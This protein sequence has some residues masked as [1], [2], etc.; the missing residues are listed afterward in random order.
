MYKVARLVVKLSR[1]EIHHFNAFVSLCAAYLCDAKPKFT[2]WN[3][4]LYRELYF[5]VSF[6]ARN[7]ML[8]LQ[9]K[10]SLE[11]MFQ[12]SPYHE[13]VLWEV[14]FLV[15][16]I[17]GFRSKPETSK[18]NSQHR[19]QFLKCVRACYA[20]CYQNVILHCVKIVASHSAKYYLYF[21]TIIYTGIHKSLSPPL[22]HS[23][24][25]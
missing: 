6:R 18:Y 13:T 9:L 1:Y 7:T 2:C 24:L 3:L 15:Y 11:I 20:T 19:R 14:G 17:H 12:Q 16:G 22:S 4:H 8:A 25:D 5:N 21:S 10:I 23:I